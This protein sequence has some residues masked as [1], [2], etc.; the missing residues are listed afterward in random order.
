MTIIKEGL[1]KEGPL[2]LMKGGL[3]HGLDLGKFMDVAL[4]VSTD[5][6]HEAQIQ[7]SCSSSMSKYRDFFRAISYEESPQSF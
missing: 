6:D 3:Q 5:V 7:F 2:F 1:K 4:R